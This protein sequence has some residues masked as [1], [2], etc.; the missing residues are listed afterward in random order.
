M[1]MIDLVLPPLICATKNK[2]HLKWK[3]ILV[4]GNDEI[5]VNYERR[6]RMLLLI[7]FI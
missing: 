1:S 3:F 7:T 5:N 2:T 4:N 6:N